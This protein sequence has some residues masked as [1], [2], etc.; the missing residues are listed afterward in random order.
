MK[1]ALEFN[2]LVRTSM[3]VFHTE[4]S[5]ENVG[6]EEYMENRGELAYRR[7]KI[8]GLP[9]NEPSRTSS[10]TLKMVEHTIQSVTYDR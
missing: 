8:H 5:Y 2:S 7:L 4:L 6:R 10:T 1:I 9:W 3:S